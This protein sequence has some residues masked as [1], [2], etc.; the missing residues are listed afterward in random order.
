MDQQDIR[1]LKILEE[2]EKDQAPSQRDMARKLNISLGL[3]NSFIKRLTQKGYF[4]VTN[5]PRNRVKYILTPKGAAEKTRLTY[6]YIKYSFSFYKT[7]RQKLREL[8]Q[9]LVNQGVT[10]IVFY[11][12]SDLTEIAYISLQEFPI[13]LA[14]V[15]DDMK[16][17]EDFFGHIIAH[18][19]M[20]DTISYDKVL[21][22]VIV[23]S[24]EIFAQLSNKGLSVEEVVMLQ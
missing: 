18:T 22:T 23:P 14:A 2:I 11:G 24:D 5:I 6:E 16:S 10:R 3:A 9:H 13:E 21:I 20:L 12:I 8:L 15:L 7:S 1:T 4:K 19:S 17:G